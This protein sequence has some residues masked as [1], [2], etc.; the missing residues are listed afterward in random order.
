MDARGWRR[1]GVGNVGRVDILA[2][3]AVFVG[4]RWVVGWSRCLWNI[5]FNWYL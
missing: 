2:I 5:G 3:C 4:L 1:D